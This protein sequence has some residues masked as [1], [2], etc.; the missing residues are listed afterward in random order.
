MDFGLRALVVLFA[1]VGAH[2]DERGGDDHGEE[3]YREDEIVNHGWTSN[4]GMGRFFQ[5]PECGRNQG[6]NI[7]QKM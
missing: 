7:P 1:V 6:A 4:R 5:I 3:D 2:C